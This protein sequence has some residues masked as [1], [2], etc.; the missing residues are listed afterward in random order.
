MV[1]V[2]KRPEIKPAD[3]AKAIEDEPLAI[4]P[5]EPQMFGTAGNNGQMIAEI[6]S[7]HRVA[8]TFRSLAK[9]LTGR[10]D[11]KVPRAGIF[12]PFAKL[13]ARATR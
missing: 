1:G 3:F 5:F 7:G 6:A 11:S 12:A 13:L 4:I 10:G 8:E 2:P 9:T